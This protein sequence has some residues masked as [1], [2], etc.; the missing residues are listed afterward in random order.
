M[1]LGNVAPFSVSTLPPLYLASYLLGLHVAQ[2]SCYSSLNVLPAYPCMILCH[3]TAIV[4]TDLPSRFKIPFSH[5]KHCKLVTFSRWQKP[6]LPSGPYYLIKACNFI[7]IWLY[8]LC[9]MLHC[10]V[11]LLH[12]C[13]LI[14]DFS[15]LLGFPPDATT[16][17]LHLIRGTKQC[18]KNFQKWNTE[19][20]LS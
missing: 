20:D 11:Y 9:E 12:V 15:P 19:S 4:C 17:C 14:T 6:M 10:N 16:L 13:C 8:Q 7:F 3:L 18:E 1:K 2:I 5:C